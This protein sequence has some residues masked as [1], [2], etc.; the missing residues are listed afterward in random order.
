MIIP[1]MLRTDNSRSA[2]ETGQP[3]GRVAVGGV[4]DYSA[5]FYNPGALSFLTKKNMS[6]SLNTYGIKDFSFINGAG[7][8]IDSRYTRVSLYPASLAGPL[9]FFGD[10]TDRFSYM[11]Y[12]TG[13]SYVRISER[14]EGYTDVILQDNHHQHLQ[15]ILKVMN[16]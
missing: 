2:M 14:Y 15:F 16:I 9:P 10:S 12:S 8:G 6:F 7:P 3:C 1:Q 5:T 4:N 13:Y 11:I